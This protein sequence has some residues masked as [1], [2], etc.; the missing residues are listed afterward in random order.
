M[1]L[2]L[3]VLATYS[4]PVPRLYIA[5]PYNYTMVT[6]EYHLRKGMVG[7]VR[8]FFPFFGNV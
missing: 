2:L 6:L 3:V 5:V 1:C 8:N 4:C 7:R